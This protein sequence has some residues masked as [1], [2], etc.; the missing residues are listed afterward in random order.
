MTDSLVLTIA[1]GLAAFAAAFGIAEWIAIARHRRRVRRE[2]DA[3][4]RLLEDPLRGGNIDC[5]DVM[6]ASDRYRARHGR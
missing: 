2:T 6:Q 4:I 3:W 5:V 1:L